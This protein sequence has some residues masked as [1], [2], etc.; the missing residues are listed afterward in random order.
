[1][2]RIGAARRLAITARAPRVALFAKRGDNGR[3]LALGCPCHDVGRGRSGAAHA[4]VERTVVAEGK[5]ARGLVE[6]H[7]GDAE[8]ENHAIHGI[9]A[10]RTRDRLQ[11]G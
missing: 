10:T 8:V 4:H 2:V 6:L 3:K 11:I 7:R 1:M 9:P 5:P